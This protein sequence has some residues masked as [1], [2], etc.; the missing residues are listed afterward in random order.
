MIE[1]MN[2]LF[3]RIPNVLMY[4]E[5]I[6]PSA[7]YL[8]GVIDMLSYY[9]E[10]ITNEELKIISQISHNSIEKYLKQLQEHNYIKI[11]RKKNSRKITPLIERSIELYQKKMKQAEIDI[12][13]KEKLKQEHE[14]IKKEIPDYVKQFVK[15]IK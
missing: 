5:R 7:K 14:T 9:T 2:P 1:K 13:E 3:I 12:K 6:V 15:E 10:S 8:Y 11:E 4:D